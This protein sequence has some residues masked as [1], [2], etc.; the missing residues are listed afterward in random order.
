MDLKLGFFGSRRLRCA[1]SFHNCL[2]WSGLEK[3]EYPDCPVPSHADVTT[4][5][6]LGG[7]LH[8]CHWV[9]GRFVKK[10]TLSFYNNFDNSSAPDDRTVKNCNPV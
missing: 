2:R 5:D 6:A 3:K 8:N 7:Q 9:R 4:V 1:D 10:L